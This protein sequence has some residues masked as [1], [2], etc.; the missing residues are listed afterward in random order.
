MAK[1][2]IYIPTPFRRHTDGAAEV[3]VEA[4]TVAE[5]LAR[6][7]ERHP[8][9]RAQVFA[10]EGALHEHLNVYLNEEEIR[11]L[12]GLDT[13]VREGD[14]LALV[15]AMA[16]GSG[17][18]AA[19]HAGAPP[20]ARVP[21]LT[22]EQLEHYSRQV[23]LEGVGVEGQAKLLSSRALIVGA[24]GLGS[25]AALYLAAAGVGTIG[26]V[27]G[28]VVDRSNLQRQ[29]LHGWDDVG[30]PKTRSAAE[31]LRAL[32]PD[33]HV[34]EHVGVLSSANAL[35]ILREYDIVVNGSD[36]FPTR[37]LVNDACVF[38]GK[39]LVDASILK[40]EGQLTVFLPGRGCY[41][42]LYPSPPPPGS[43]PSCAE[44]GI[45]GAVAGVMGALQAAE[46]VKV[47]IGAGEPLANRLLLFD[48]FSGRFR[49]L[50]WRR[51]PQCPVCGEAPTIRELVDYEAFCGVPA[52]RAAAAVAAEQE[53]PA[54][55]AAEAG[56]PAAETV[57]AGAPA[58]G[59]VKPGA[60]A[61]AAVTA[62]PDAA[63]APDFPPAG[64]TEVPVAAAATR[65]DD[66]DVVFF[67]VREPHEYERGHIPGSRLLPLD[68]LA[69][70]MA[71]I[72]RDRVCIFVCDRGVKSGLA[73]EI[74]R[75]G[76][77]E[78]AYNLQGG[79]LAWQNR[80]LPLAS[81]PEGRP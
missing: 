33:V 3:E 56:A 60:P 22:D 66:P 53:A 20:G 12:Q 73:V 14:E 57:T 70:R 65:I 37:Y 46:A 45:L 79:L 64:G 39:P 27:D 21:L 72:P 7:A 48:A 69:R 36:N 80:R 18:A 42:C 78:R 5:A 71:E 44:G 68:D 54:G 76:G 26:I 9:L 28:D 10:A 2:S 47:I 58:T 51:H 31:T 1:V 81:G 6:L 67:D 52:P 32:N 74:L 19:E 59:T 8:G 43:V 41:R 34:V 16:G 63:P 49:T 13:P 24:G 4:A 35:E 62:P 75:A 29:I 77:H 17:P 61:A 50:N 40:W 23:L 25:P 11:A 55:A 15:P 30:R 38:L